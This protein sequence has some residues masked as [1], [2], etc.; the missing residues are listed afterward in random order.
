[1]I[2]FEE[3]RD[4]CLDF[5][6]EKGIDV[7][8][9]PRAI[10]Q[11]E[12]PDIKPWVDLIHRAEGIIGSNW[13][14]TDPSPFKQVAALSMAIVEKAPLPDTIP[15]ELALDA[16][17]D[18]NTAKM[19]KS[20]KAMIALELAVEYLSTSAVGEN[21]DDP[22]KQL[23]NPISMSGHFRKDFLWVLATRSVRMDSFNAISLIYEALAY[24]ANPDAQNDDLT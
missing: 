17:L 3:V 24:K 4:F 11:G 8:A 5:C 10:E 19:P 18:E 2:T 7:E 13:G 20:L 16:G 15:R 12:N 1:M 14:Y 23:K 22:R 21:P 9:C 6:E